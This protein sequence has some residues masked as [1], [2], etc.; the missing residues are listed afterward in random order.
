VERS[1]VPGNRVGV[2]ALSIVIGVGVLVPVLAFWI[3]WTVKT[4]TPMPGAA[5]L[6]FGVADW[7]GLTLVVSAII[8]GIGYILHR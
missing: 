1:N 5:A 8:G 6:V 3:E 4:A 2:T 7:I